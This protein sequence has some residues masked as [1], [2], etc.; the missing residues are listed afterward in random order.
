[1]RACRGLNNCCYQVGPHIIKYK[2]YEYEI[3]A[4]CSGE[5]GIKYVEATKKLTRKGTDYYC[6]VED[7]IIKI[8]LYRLLIKQLEG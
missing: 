5:K 7:Y 8:E 2:T 3:T 4:I 6:T 1:M